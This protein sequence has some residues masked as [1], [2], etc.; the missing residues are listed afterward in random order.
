MPSV[1]RLDRSRLR[2]FRIAPWLAG[3]LLL[4]WAFGGPLL[5]PE[6]PSLLSVEAPL[7]GA[8]VGPEGLEVLVRFA[9][10]R[11]A[12]E[13]FRA[14]LNGA[15]VTD[16]LTTGENGAWGRLYG[17]L[18]GEN[19]LRVEVFGRVWTAGDRLV[20]Q[21]REVRVRARRPLDLHRG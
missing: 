4:T 16:D 15:E 17:L 14:L 9:P 1:L 13:T 20:E 7:A 3:V 5:P 12:S 11:A 6:G 8:T 18:D 2:R 21:A 19:V 10:G